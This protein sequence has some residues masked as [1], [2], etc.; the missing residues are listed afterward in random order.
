MLRSTEI[1]SKCFF[2]SAETRR[3]ITIWSIVAVRNPPQALTMGNA[4]LTNGLRRLSPRMLRWTYGTTLTAHSSA[5][6]QSALTFHTKQFVVALRLSTFSICRSSSNEVKRDSA[7]C[8]LLS[9][10]S[11]MMSDRFVPL[12]SNP[13]SCS[14][15]APTKFHR[16]NEIPA[17]S[18]L[19]PALTIPRLPKIDIGVAAT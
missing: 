5:V 9:S 18:P 6:K 13:A 10:G 1:E 14:F 8:L 19:N 15:C 12:G 7:R 2:M 4:H 11:S 17:T 16:G 3:C